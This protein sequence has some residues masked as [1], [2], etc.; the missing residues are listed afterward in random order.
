MFLEFSC[1]K[2]FKIYQMDVKPTFLNG[3]LEEEVYIE[4]S[5]GFHLLEYGDYASKLN[6]S[7]YGL[8]Q[9]PRAWYSRLNKHLQQ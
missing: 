1:Y 9:D 7:L 6:K 8:K 2:N 3:N 5:E 4:K